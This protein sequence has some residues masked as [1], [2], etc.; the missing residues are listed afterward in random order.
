MFT[1]QEVIKKYRK[2]FHFRQWVAIFLSINLISYGFPLETLSAELF[3]D[4]QFE[5]KLLT[6]QVSEPA[7]VGL[8]RQLKET[9][10]EAIKRMINEAIKNI[11]N[12]AIGL[13]PTEVDLEKELR[14]MIEDPLKKIIGE[15]I[16][17]LIEENI[18]KTFPTK[19]SLEL[20]IER[21][22]R[23][24]VEDNI[25]G[26]LDNAIKKVIEEPPDR[27]PTKIGY[28]K[29]SKIIDEPVKKMMKEIAN[30][31][32][33]EVTPPPVTITQIPAE[34]TPAPEPVTPPPA[35][36]TPTVE[37]SQV[38]QYPPA[39]P[40]PPAGIGVG[41][42]ILGGVLIAG[43]A[44]ALAVALAGSTKK[45]TS[46][47]G[48]SGGSICGNV[49]Y[50]SC[51]GSSGGGRSV[52]CYVTSTYYSSC[53]C[54]SGTKYG[55][56][57]GIYYLCNCKPT[58]SI[59]KGGEQSLK[60]FPSGITLFDSNLSLGLNL[61]KTTFSINGDACYDIVGMPTST[62][63]LQVKGEYSRKS[64]QFVFSPFV[65]YQLGNGSVDFTKED[66]Y[67]STAL[68][69]GMDMMY[70]PYNLTLSSMI[71]QAIRSEDSEMFDAA[72]VQLTLKY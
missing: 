72:V 22:L 71:R 54:P 34:V 19:L 38:P 46:T 18:G 17:K 56:R 51:C 13:V 39:E 41:G 3:K 65:Q 58:L 10:R 62:L 30:V 48:G 59:V 37:P 33:P 12:E 57:T 47:G 43:G 36:P 64:G 68:L 52:A 11:V 21:Q 53:G 26:I 32:L 70:I 14:Q 4:T 55:G 28:F 45:T 2:R 66:F 9:I 60:T 27:P 7:E 49:T 6:A 15:A 29:R 50:S 69:Y 63:G 40:P 25:K 24:M 35:K 20:S 42:A 8:E 44:V 23:L 1:V 31:T 61:F 16:K 5:Q 67:T